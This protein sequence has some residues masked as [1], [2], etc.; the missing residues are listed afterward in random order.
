MEPKLLW[1]HFDELRKIPRCSKHEEAAA[2]YVVTVARRLGLEYIRDSVGNVVVKMPATPGMEISPTVVLQAHLDMVCEKNE[3]VLH[4]FS[5]DPIEVVRE[6]DYLQARGTT[7]G[8]DNGIGVSA[9]LAILEEKSAVHGP[10]ELLFTVDEEEGMSGAYGLRGDALTGR[11]LINLDTED[12]ST[13]YIGCAGGAKT[14]IHLPV[15]RERSTGVALL[16]SLKG[17]SGGHSGVDIHLERGNSNKLLARI[18]SEAYGCVPFNLADISG[19]NKHNAIPRESVALVVIQKEDVG[20]LRLRIA[21]VEEALLNEYRSVD[22]GLL[23]NISPVALPERMISLEDSRKVLNLILALP[24]GVMRWSPELAGTVETSVNLPVVQ[25]KENEIF[26]I[27]ASRSFS[28]TQL[29]AQTE[30]IRAIADLAGA[31][32][33]VGS[34]YPGW[35]PRM[36]SKILKV[37]ELSYQELFGRE[38]QIKAIHAGLETGIIGKKYPEMEMISLGPQIEHAHSP[39]ER[40]KI[41]T[42]KVFYDLILKVLVRI[43]GAV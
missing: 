18:L 17:L 34:S 43:P 31:E 2:D 28:E 36:D 21:E 40:V 24:T 6:G 7:L 20:R 8:A 27:M 39:D 10:L 15:R 3:E 5:K 13:L 25:T 33:R 14:R 16:V 38:P 4:D 41:S 19:G 35:Q 11:Y 12:G 37:C 23:V 30:R 22:P 26:L 29:K 42:V 9:E 1:K 32:V